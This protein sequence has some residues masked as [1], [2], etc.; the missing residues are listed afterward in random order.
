MVLI[1][2]GLVHNF[3]RRDLTAGPRRPTPPWTRPPTPPASST[4]SWPGTSNVASTSAC[5]TTRSST[6]SP[7]WPGPGAEDPTRVVSRC[8]QDVAL[9]E[10]ALGDQDNPAAGSGARARRPGRG[11]AG[12]RRRPARP[13]AERRRRYRR[14]GRIDRPG[15]GR[16]GGRERHPRGAV[17][18]SGARGDRGGLGAGPPDHVGRGSRR[19]RAA[20]EVTVRDRGRASTSTGSTGPAS[21]SAGRLPSAS[22]TAAGRRRSGRRPGAARSCACVLAWASVDIRTSRT[23][24]RSGRTACGSTAA[25]PRRT[26]HEKRAQGRG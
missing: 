4:P 15:P 19:L 26:R 13:R 7:P 11:G 17:Q 5:C 23:A 10:D 12:R 24:A 22:P 16:R 1:V 21:A 14:R 3:S 2:V 25:S 20:C 9:I 6:R 8:R 18:R